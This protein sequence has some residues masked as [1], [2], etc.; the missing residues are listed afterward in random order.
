[1][2]VQGRELPHAVQHD[3]VRYPGNDFHYIGSGRLDCAAQ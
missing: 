3:D 1:M 2:A